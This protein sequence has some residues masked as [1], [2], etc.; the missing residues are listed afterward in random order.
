MKRV[1]KCDKREKKEKK[2]LKAVD[3]ILIRRKRG[4]GGWGTKDGSETDG[5]YGKEELAF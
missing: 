4:L 1:C 2:T 5:D 3:N